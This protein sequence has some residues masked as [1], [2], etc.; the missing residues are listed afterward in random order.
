MIIS[1]QQDIVT[2][3]QRQRK[4]A[5]LARAPSWLDR[6]SCALSERPCGR[7]IDLCYYCL[8]CSPD[9]KLPCD[10]VCLR[11]KG[12][13]MTVEEKAQKICEKLINGRHHK[14]NHSFEAP[15]APSDAR[16]VNELKAT[17]RKL[18]R[19]ECSLQ[20]AERK[21]DQAKSSMAAVTEQKRQK[22]I[23]RNRRKDFL[24]VISSP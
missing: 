16:L 21:C 11:P 7:R 10:T 4:A 14:H 18:T 17:K 6:S 22:T 20:C 24:L 23:A 1:M 9:K 19:A 8:G 5:L 13:G 15:E 12:P 2:A 3:A